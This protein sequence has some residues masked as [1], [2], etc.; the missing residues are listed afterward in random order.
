MVKRCIHIEGGWRE[1]NRSLPSIPDQAARPPEGCGA[2][3]WKAFVCA[4]SA[5]RGALARRGEVG[6]GCSL[7]AYGRRHF[8]WFSLT[9]LVSQK[10]LLCA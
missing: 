1:F 3:G 10:W 4:R 2:L 8:A 9:V 7:L 6:D 5:A